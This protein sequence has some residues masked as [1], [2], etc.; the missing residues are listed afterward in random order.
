MNDN[1]LD[2]MKLGDL[3]T[4]AGLF[5]GAPPCASPWKVGGKYL[6]RTCTLYYTGRVASV[7]AQEIELNEAAAIYDTGRHADAIRTGEVKEA[8]PVGSVII[9]RGAIVSAE[10]WEHQLPKEQK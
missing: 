9:G 10:P 3:K 5:G 1:A 6:V 7:S 2:N 4:L 8:E